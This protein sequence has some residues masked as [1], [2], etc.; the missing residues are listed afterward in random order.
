MSWVHEADFVRAVEYLMTTEDIEGVVNVAAPSPLPNRDF[1]RALRAAWGKRFG[2]S[3]KEWM[4]EFGAV[5]LRTK[6]ELILKSRRVVPG[7]LLDHGFRFAFPEWAAAARD[8]VQTWSELN[9]SRRR[10]Q[11]SALQDGAGV[12]RPR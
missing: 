12:A 9:Q 5:F 3:A 1:M 4:L 10:R 2:L 11:A 7:R 6:T 8:L